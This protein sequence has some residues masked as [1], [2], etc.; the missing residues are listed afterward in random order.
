MQ[1]STLLTAPAVLQNSQKT[2]K[3]GVW[4]DEVLLFLRASICQ[5]TSMSDQ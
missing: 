1:C 2:A 5:V 3:S 4:L